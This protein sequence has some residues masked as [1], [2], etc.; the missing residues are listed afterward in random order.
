ASLS[1]RMARQLAD[2]RHFYDRFNPAPGD[3]NVWSPMSRLRLD[4]PAL[5]EGATAALVRAN[6]AYDRC[7]TQAVTRAVA[8]GELVPAT[9]IEIV[10]RILR[11]T[12]LS[13]GPV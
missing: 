7:L 8:R 1:E 6:A 10:V 5:G 13:C 2:L 9:P 12:F 11:V 4:L 3:R